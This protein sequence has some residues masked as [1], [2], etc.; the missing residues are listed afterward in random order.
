MRYNLEVLNDK[1]FEDLAKDLLDN[2]LGKEFEIFKAGRDCGIDLRYSGKFPNEI[3]VQV[4]HYIASKFSDL[5]T[6][7]AKEKINLDKLSDKP[8]KY[9]VFTSMSLSP[10][11]KQEIINILH[12]YIKNSGDIYNRRMIENLISKTPT[13]ERKYFKLWLT[14]TNVMLQIL[15]NAEYLTSEF[16]E[17]KIIKR[18]KFY[19]QTNHLE[20]AFKSLNDNKFLIISGEPGVGKTTL[21]YMLVYELL[22][23][24]YKLIYSDREIRDAE[25]ILSKKN[26][27]KQVVLIDDFLGSNLADVYNPVNPENTI[28]RFVES[29]KSSV[30]KYLIFT[31]RTTLLIEANQRFEHFERERIKD[32]S[33]YELKVSKYT[34]L[35]KAKI[36]YNHLYHF[37][38]SNEFMDVFF[39]KKNY[40]K[41]IEHPNYYPRL[42]EFLTQESNFWGSGFEN[43]EDFLFEN[44]NNPKKIWKMAFEN[45][46]T[47][48]D[49]LFLETLFTF[50]DQGVDSDIL[51]QAL[52]KRI[53]V[54]TKFGRT[55]HGINIFN[56]CLNKLQDGFLKTGR[57]IK[58]HK[59]HIS[60]INPSV[61]DFLL[62]YLIENHQER[63][64]IWLSNIFIE[65]YEKRFGKAKNR[66]L[67]YREYEIDIY[68]NSLLDNFTLRSVA[69]TKNCSFRIL[70]LLFD[71]FPSRISQK[72]PQVVELLN[73]IIQNNANVDWNFYFILM[74]ILIDEYDECLVFVNN[75]WIKIINLM[76][77]N[78]DSGNEIR[79]VVDLHFDYQKDFK[80]Y[81]NTEEHQYLFN[82]AVQKVFQEILDD[83]DLTEC[84]R[85]DHEGYIHEEYS[86]DRIKE[87]AWDIYQDFL[88]EEKLI[89]FVHEND[90]LYEVDV[91]KVIQQHIDNQSYYHNDIS[92]HGKIDEEISDKNIDKEI[93]R[94][95]HR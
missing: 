16:Q 67:S 58:T 33:N 73:S 22:A 75:H 92:H 91:P 88:N 49:Q 61:T 66:Y 93:E 60:F 8:R 68:L 84:V 6:Q 53:E 42:I 46:L 56:T 45:Q 39:M 13:V 5:K 21:A 23:K 43:V 59:L 35:E 3:I 76:L 10:G 69:S 4:K 89:E 54:E 55:L 80:E 83:Q 57:D 65:Q 71:M 79:Y 78:I 9:I 27:D 40:L 12:P 94:I 62:D 72:Q 29:I 15:H 48:E 11:Q 82:E 70:K 51:Q 24:G 87:K 14:S 36:L 26:E 1:E 25:K 31:S 32:I 47:R 52:D 2:K 50:G 20:N 38:I 37:N 19:I 28:I 64:M 90:A 18:A 7:L 34:K 63:K 41:I 95:F 86:E 77:Q 81:L 17:L 44:L 85:F 30:N 74:S